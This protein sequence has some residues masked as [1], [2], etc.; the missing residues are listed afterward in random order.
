M[1]H[2][3]HGASSGPSLEDVLKH[4]LLFCEIRH[5][6]GNPTTQKLPRREEAQD[7]SVVGLCGETDSTHDS[8]MAFDF[9]DQT[10]NQHQ[11][12]ANR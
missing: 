2:R 3:C 4:L 1:W 5:H 11:H 10:K 6:L 7:T 12:H 8:E 9:L